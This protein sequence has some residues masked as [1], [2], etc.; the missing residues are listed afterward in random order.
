MGKAYVIKCP[1]G[2]QWASHLNRCEHP[3]LARCS[4]KPAVIKPAQ[5]IEEFDSEEEYDYEYFEDGP[6]I[7]DDPDFKINDAR[8]SPDDVDIFHPVQ[9]AHPEDCTMF[10][11]CFDHMAYKIQCP[12]GLHYSVKEGQC[13]YQEQAQCNAGVMAAQAQ[14]VVHTPTVPTCPKTGS[15]NLS[16]EGSFTKYFTCMNGLAYFMECQVEEIFN[17]MSKKCEK[18]QMPQYPMMPGFPGGQFQNQMPG[19]MQQF[20]GGMQQYPGMQI[21]MNPMN[22]QIPQIPIAP[23]KFPNLIPQPQ[24]PEVER[25]QLPEFP[26]WMPVPN[27]NVQIPE[28]PIAEKPSHEKPEKNEFNYQNGKPNSRCP[29]SDNPSKP[30]HLAHESEW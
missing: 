17:P 3:Q 10:Y 14:S 29:S 28:M 2:Q 13:D 22:P 25:P 27:P 15:V 24:T 21:P 19:F 30:E 20:P 1:K 12:G 26:S 23:P 8:C 18:F 16:V 11:K 5:A 6:T 7:A 9:F 4:I